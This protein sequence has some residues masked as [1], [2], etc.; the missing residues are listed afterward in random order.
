MDT[1]MIN[2]IRKQVIKKLLDKKGD[3]SVY[4][5]TLTAIFIIFILIAFSIC[6]LFVNIYSVVYD[7]KMDLYNLNKSAVIS[8]NKVKGSYGIYE[9]DK[10]EYLEKF[11]EML[12]KSY[13]LD[14]NLKNG[15][16]FIKQI[17]ILEYEIYKNGQTDSITKKHIQNDTIHVVTNITFEPILFKF[18]FPNNC[19]FK[20]HNDISIKLYN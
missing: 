2:K 3:M 5:I 14:I 16:K 17:E 4:V 15:S 18:I 7:Y 1:I 6:V 9:Y 10:N 8:V 11:K 12:I 19:T 20:L 13:N